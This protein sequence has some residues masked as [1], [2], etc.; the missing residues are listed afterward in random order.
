MQIGNGDILNNKKTLLKTTSQS[1]EFLSCLNVQIYGYKSTCNVL[2]QPIKLSRKAQT[3]NQEDVEGCF[4]YFQV[5]F[6]QNL[7]N[8]VPTF[9]CSTQHQL[10]MSASY[11]SILL[12]NISLKLNVIEASCIVS[13]IY[14][15][16]RCSD[17]NVWIYK[18]P[19]QCQS[20]LKWRV[21]TAE[22][23]FRG[24]YQMVLGTMQK[25]WNAFMPNHQLLNTCCLFEFH[26]YRYWSI[27]NE[28][29]WFILSV[30]QILLDLK[31]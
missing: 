1:H 24:M 25:T 26:V 18:N 14:L 20:S 15:R 5:N 22:H 8:I 29:L 13:K 2:L 16:L 9:W 31:S 19:K 17:Q 21:A 27:C 3:R 11:F 30:N 6:I 7:V 28:K 12:L 10:V 4:W 23:N